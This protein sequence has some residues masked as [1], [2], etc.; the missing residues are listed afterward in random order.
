MQ[1]VGLNIEEYADRYPNQLSG[2]QQQR[3]GV[4]RALA[5]EPDLILMDEPFSALDP[6]TRSDLQDQMVELQNKMK[7]TVVFVTHDMDE[8]I[9]LADMICIMKDGCIIQYDTP[10][11]IL[12][13]PADDFVIGF[14]GKKR[15]WSSPEYIKVKDIM[16]EHPITA[17][18]HLSV[19]GCMEKM[20]QSK[21]DSLMIIDP[22]S[23]RMMG[24]VKAKQLRS[25]EDRSLPAEAV[26]VTNY[27]FLAPEQTILDALR[28]V[29]ERQV[30]TIPVVDKQGIL[31]GLITK[32]SLVTTLSHQYLEVE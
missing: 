15:I 11:N 16:L 17:A 32:S 21:V 4:A 26:M 25:L 30:S 9:K 6:I 7:K 19:L 5:N 10:E 2:G 13:N 22:V 20:R 24:I 31:L 29:N 14:I 18:N 28:I 27:S 1:M 23:R 12:K 3:V 8:A